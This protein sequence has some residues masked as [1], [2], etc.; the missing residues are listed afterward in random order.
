MTIAKSYT[1]IWKALRQRKLGY[2]MDFFMNGKDMIFINM[3]CI[4]RYTKKHKFLS[5]FT[6]NQSKYTFANKAHL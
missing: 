1:A 2:F 4:L 6:M 3:I 5:V